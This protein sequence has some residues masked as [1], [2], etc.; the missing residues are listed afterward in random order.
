[1]IGTAYL[2]LLFYTGPEAGAIGVL[3]NCKPSKPQMESMTSA[4]SAKKRA[5]IRGGSE[6]APAA[7]H[8]ARAASLFPSA[9]N[10][11][12]RPVPP[13]RLPGGHTPVVAASA[14][15]SGAVQ[16]RRRRF[17]QGM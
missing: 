8:F 16:A 10:H 17:T 9:R 2:W 1:V 7:H 12:T 6:F 3:L 5:G 14:A 15:V 4:A 11:G 13:A